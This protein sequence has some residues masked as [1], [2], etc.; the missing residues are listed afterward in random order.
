MLIH[1]R[2]EDGTRLTE[3]EL[4]GQANLLFLAGHET[5]ANALTWTLFLLSQHPQVLADLH[6]ELSGKLH[7]DPPTVEQMAEL[8]LLERVIKESMRLLP[9]VPLGSRTATK[10]TELGPYLLPQ[11][12]EIVFSQYHTHHAAD[13]YPEPE[14]FRPD[15]WLGLNPSAYEY[16]PFGGGPRLCVGAAFAMM[17]MK[18][19]LPLLLQRYR[20]ELVPG[21]RIDRFV[22]MTMAPKYGMPMVVRPQDRE[23][24]RGKT[25]VHGDVREM[26][27]L[28]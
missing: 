21:A 22:N 3:D 15:R 28:D 7:G 17:E 23:F 27:E 13:L 2:D 25:A 18:V 1:A 10:P 8:P 19:V 4:I 26:V 20:L 24:A 12:T 6:D 14:R 16:I 9:P 11:W 5:T